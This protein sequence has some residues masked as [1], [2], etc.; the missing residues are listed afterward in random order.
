MT[1]SMNPLKAYVYVTVGVPI[2]A[3]PVANLDDLAEFITIAATPAQ[4][5]TAVDAAL[6]SG[7][8]APT[9]EAL[10]ALS[11][12]ERIDQ[13]LALVDQVPVRDTT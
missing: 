12:P 6:Q 3:T 5:V 11:W 4:F 1:R 9:D 7:R 2:V 10:R 8:R 13:V